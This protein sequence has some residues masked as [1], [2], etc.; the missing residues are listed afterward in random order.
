MKK[1]SHAT[2]VEHFILPVVLCLL[3]FLG[4]SGGVCYGVL[5]EFLG[6]SS[7]EIENNY[8][9]WA[10]SI[11]TVL[12]GVGYWLLTLAQK[13]LPDTTVM[14]EP[15][16]SDT[17][18][19]RYLVGI[20]FALLADALLCSMVI[21]AMTWSVGRVEDDVVAEGDPKLQ[22]MERDRLSAD[23]DAPEELMPDFVGPD[24]VGSDFV[25]PIWPP[26]REKLDNG[27]SRILGQNQQDAASVSVLFTLSIFF[28]LLGA[29]FFFCSTMWRKMHAPD[30][31]PFVSALF[32]AGLWFRIGEALVFN[33][34]FYLTFRFF[35]IK[36]FFIL[37]L[38]SLLV[39]MFLKS[40]EV[41]VSGIA[42]RVFAAV[43]EL[44][45]VATAAIDAPELLVVNLSDQ[46]DDQ[47][48]IDACK[49]HIEQLSGVGRVILDAAKRV[50][51]AEFDPKRITRKRLMHELHL[52]GV[53]PQEA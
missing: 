25:G 22:A 18:Y 26:D 42:S 52:R 19:S 43:K 35:A 50:L 46:T 51:T 47:S 49:S 37:P 8:V 31:E 41:L 23:G 32:W 1:E 16:R 11:G 6:I 30:R 40:G 3:G 28:A 17:L 10:L 9:Y 53:C 20:G 29:L 27:T 48:D 44:V 5:P 24:F 2:H 38:I 14:E 33:I 7:V 21:S 34:V 12:S 36:Q 45:P 39:G 13:K 4:I 15:V